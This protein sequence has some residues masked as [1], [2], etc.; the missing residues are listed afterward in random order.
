[1]GRRIGANFFGFWPNKIGDA[2]CDVGGAVVH[3]EM[4]I[5]DLSRTRDVALGPSGELY[6]LLEHDSGGRIVRLVPATPAR[7]QQRTQ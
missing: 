1:M 5:K 6:L 7:T 2:R 4:L 3:T